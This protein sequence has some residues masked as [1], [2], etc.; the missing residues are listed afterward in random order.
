MTT[1][2]DQVTTDTIEIFGRSYSLRVTPLDLRCDGQSVPF[3]ADAERADLLICGR[4]PDRLSLN[5][6]AAVVAAC[7]EEREYADRPDKPP[8][9]YGPS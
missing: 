2:Q 7:Q 1:A 9:C 5:V 3:I 4:Q 8:R 6:A